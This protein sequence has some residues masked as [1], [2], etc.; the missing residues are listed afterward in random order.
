MKI[1]KYTLTILLVLFAFQL[2]NQAQQDTR[3]SHFTLNGLRYNPA[4]AGIKENLSFDA[5]YRR[6][7]TQIEDAPK[8]FSIA[9]HD[10]FFKNKMGLGLFIENDQAGIDNRTNAFLSYAYKIKMKKGILSAG[11]QG[12]LTFFRSDLTS[13]ETPE[14]GF[15][16]SFAQDEQSVLPNFGAGLFYYRDNYYIGFSVPHLLTY[17]KSKDDLHTVNRLKGNY[18]EYTFTMGGD[19]EINEKLDFRPAVLVQYIP[20]ET[21]VEVS[22]NVSF[23]L[24]ENAL[25]GIGYRSNEMVNPESF[26]FLLAY[27]MDNGLKIGYSY[28]HTL[29]P[30]GVY[31]SGGHEIMIGYDLGSKKDKAYYR[32]QWLW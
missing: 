20:A 19:L 25:L 2:E 15:D 10:D 28:D 31:T 27:K 9:L 12:G 22:L 21:P 16:A 3:Y 5:F 30:I 26:N 6:Q 13:I 4:F 29:A 14:G 24:K 8:D 23:I 11:L 7:W 17:Q 1:L 32:P 18:R